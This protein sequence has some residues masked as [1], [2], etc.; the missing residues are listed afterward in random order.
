[1]SSESDSFSGDDVIVSSGAA[2]TSELRQSSSNIEAVHCRE[3][4]R[5]THIAGPTSATMRSV[6]CT[7]IVVHALRIRVARS[8][9][10]SSFVR[11]F[12]LLDVVEHHR[13]LRRLRIAVHRVDQSSH[14]PMHASL[15]S[16]DVE[17]QPRRVAANSHQHHC[18]RVLRRLRL[19]ELVPVCARDTRWRS[20]A[21]A[22]ARRAATTC[23]STS[24]LRGNPGNADNR[25]RQHGRLGDQRV[26]QLAV[27]ARLQH[28][29][30]HRR[31]SG[32]R[33]RARRPS[34]LHRQPSAATTATQLSGGAL[35]LRSQTCRRRAAASPARVQ[36]GRRAAAASRRPFAPASTVRCWL[37]PTLICSARARSLTGATVATTSMAS[38]GA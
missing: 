16:I 15:R 36:F 14:V 32:E 21:V 24:A 23:S 30:S 8:P 37:A 1:M 13:Q 17:R 27:I 12:D 29:L 22:D 19:L 6:H 4:H 5:H 18:R 25:R 35:I 28:C 2:T 9:T 38:S 10:H 26:Q 11:R 31:H 34:L 7:D 33:M 3:Q 20:D